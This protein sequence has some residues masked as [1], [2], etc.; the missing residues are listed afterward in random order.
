MEWP[1]FHRDGAWNGKYTGVFHGRVGDNDAI[2]VARTGE[3]RVLD[4][5]TRSDVGCATMDGDG[6]RDEH[7]GVFYQWAQLAGMRRKCV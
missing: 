3:L 7:G 4:M 1:E 2:D 6:T 5:G